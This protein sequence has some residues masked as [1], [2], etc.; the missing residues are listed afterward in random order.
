MSDLD[1]LMDRDPLELSSQDLDAIIAYQRKHRANLEGGKG[2]AKKEQGPGLK[3][4]LAALGLV[5]KPTAVEPTIKRR[6]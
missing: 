2:K 6:V 5:A 3:L 1:E 4:D